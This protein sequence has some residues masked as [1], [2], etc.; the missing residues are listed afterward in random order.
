MLAAPGRGGDL[1]RRVGDSNI[2]LGLCI[3]LLFPS[4]TSYQE[5]RE[6]NAAMSDIEFSGT[7]SDPVSDVNPEEMARLM[8]DI[9]DIDDDL[10]K[11]NLKSTSKAGSST[12]KAASP[13]KK[14]TKR[15]VTFSEKPAPGKRDND[16]DDDD[17]M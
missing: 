2:I 13:E 11:S 10:F 1:H 6:S 16:N 15:Q 4:L 12:S 3:D 5:G 8:A 17:G 14:E 7:D 9:D